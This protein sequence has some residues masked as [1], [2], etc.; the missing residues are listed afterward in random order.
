MLLNPCFLSDHQL[1]ASNNSHF[2]SSHFFAF[3]FPSQYQWFFLSLLPFLHYTCTTRTAP[4]VVH[5]T[6]LSPVTWGLYLVGWP[7]TNTPC[8]NNFFF[9]FHSLSKAIL[10]TAELPA[11]CN[12]CDVVSSISQLFVPH[13][14]MSAFTC[15]YLQR[16]INK[17][18]NTSFKFFSIL[19][20]WLL[21]I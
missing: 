15:I 4:C 6:K 18:R 1:K 14:A 12:L 17:Q 13:F 5:S 9:C 11:L 19:F 16:R 3:Y 10:K 20:S 21:V 8:G 2:H 7:K